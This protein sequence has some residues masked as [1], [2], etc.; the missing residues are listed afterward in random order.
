MRPV[1][2]FAIGVVW[3]S[4][5]A[6]VVFMFASDALADQIRDPIVV[7]MGVL[8]LVA[9]VRQSYAF[10]VAHAELIKQYEFMHRTFLKARQRIDVAGSDDEKRHIMKLLGKAALEEHSEWILTQRERPIDEGEIWRM[11]G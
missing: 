3:V 7:L 5:I 10:S 8:L 6:F 4:I 9:G 11:T 2:R 1:E